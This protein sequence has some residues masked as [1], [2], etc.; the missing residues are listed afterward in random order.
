MRWFSWNVR[1]CCF[2]LL[3]A[4]MMAVFACAHSNGQVSDEAAIFEEA[5][6]DLSTPALVPTSPIAQTFNDWIVPHRLGYGGPA[7]EWAFN[8]GTRLYLWN[9]A[10]SFYAADFRLEFTGQEAFFTAEN[11]NLAHFVFNDYGPWQTSITSELYLNLP[12]DDNILTDFALRESFANNFDIETL[13]L[14]QLFVTIGN[15]DWALDLGRFVTP[16]GRFVAPTNSNS[17]FDAPFIRTESILFRETGLQLRYNPGI[18]RVAAAATN[19]SDGRDTNSS[20]AIVARVGIETAD[21]TAGASVKW[22]DGIGS[23][24]QKEFNNHAGVDAA[25]Y[26]GRWTFSGEWIYDQYGLRRPGLSLD[27]IDF[28]R[29]I[30]NR[31]LNNGLNNPITGN[32]WYVNAIRQTPRLLLALSYGQFHPELLGDPIHDETTRRFIAKGIYRLSPHLDLLSTTIIENDVEEGQAGRV[33]RGV[34]V[35]LGLQVNF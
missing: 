16:F 23:E 27:E 20:K 12:F 11:Q 2:T 34:A 24:G 33:R 7:H 15:G 21:L 35:L 31:Q 8:N 1:R 10:R 14:S 17:R 5:L 22:Q 25:I 26:R 32:G 18:W 9:T 29:S 6:P 28:G 19:G 3:L 13:E 4:M 30:Y